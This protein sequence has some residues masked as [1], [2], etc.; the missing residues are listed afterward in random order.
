MAAPADVA[1]ASSRTNSNATTHTV[2]IPPGSAGDMLIVQFCCDATDGGVAA[3][4]P[5][6]WIVTDVGTNGSTMKIG[7]K[8]RALEGGSI[9]VTTSAAERSTHIAR[10]IT[11]HNGI[12]DVLITAATGN[13]ANHDAPVNNWSATWSGSEDVLVIAAAA[14]HDGDRTFT[15]T[16]PPNYSNGVAVDEGGVQAST[17]WCA[18]A[19]ASR[20]VT[21]AG[22]EN[23]GPFASA[24][25][26]DSTFGT[27][28]L[29][30]AATIAVRGY[31]EP[32][33]IYAQTKF[34]VYLDTGQ[35]A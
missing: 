32:A 21:G 28:T 34:R 35:E 30:V 1:Q 14:V 7:R 20:Q 23:P 25:A 3:S 29:Y 27:S 4:F 19:S 18:S 15:T 17:V 5:S 13:N 11:G 9:T 12:D 31:V 10:N 6:G 16:A 24:N 2:S 33:P 26:G 22:S 8:I